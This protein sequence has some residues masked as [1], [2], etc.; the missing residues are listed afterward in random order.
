MDDR[1]GHGNAVAKVLSAVGARPLF[2]EPAPI[3]WQLTPLAGADGL[4]ADSGDLQ[5]EG[6]ALGAPC[7][8]V[9]RLR[10]R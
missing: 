7:G 5:K 4:I 9:G 10:R 2:V 1:A 8:T 6:L 3:A